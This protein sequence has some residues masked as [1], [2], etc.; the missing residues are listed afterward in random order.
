MLSLLKKI[1]KVFDDA[2]KRYETK[3]EHCGHIMKGP[4]TMCEKCNTPVFPSRE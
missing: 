4:H 1:F 2:S 3:C